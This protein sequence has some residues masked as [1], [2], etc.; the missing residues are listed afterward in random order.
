MNVS[1]VVVSHGAN[2]RWAFGR[3]GMHRP[4]TARTD[5]EAENAARIVAGNER[6]VR[7]FVM[8]TARSGSP[9]CDDRR[10]PEL[11]AFD[12]RLVG[13]SRSTLHAQLIAAAA[14]PAANSTIDVAR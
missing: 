2:G 4:G 12:D 5:D 13:L 14:I 1:A 11:C 8:G 9:D 6:T 10:G 7:I 3:D